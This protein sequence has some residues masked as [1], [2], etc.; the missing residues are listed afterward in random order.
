V[1]V[2]LLLTLDSLAMWML[3]R[4]QCWTS[5]GNKVLQLYFQFC[6]YP[7]DTEGW[8]NLAFKRLPIPRTSSVILHS[9]D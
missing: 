5:F 6:E 3:K 7:K 1:V 8:R 9:R 4:L 2:L